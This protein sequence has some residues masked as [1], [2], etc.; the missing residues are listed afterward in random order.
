MSLY[1]GSNKRI[2]NVTKCFFF[3]Y[4]TH[5]TYIILLIYYIDISEDD[6]I[7]YIGVIYTS[8]E[9]NVKYPYS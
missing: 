6:G 4:I 2:F 7:R 1:V 8:G 3:F 5:N 9:N